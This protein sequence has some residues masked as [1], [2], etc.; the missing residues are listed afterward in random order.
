MIKVIHGEIW[1]EDFTQ[2]NQLIKEF[3]SCVRFAYNRFH[4]DNLEFNDVRKACKAKYPTLNTRQVSDAVV[5]GQALQTRH[6]DE[7]IIF[8]GRKAWEYLKAGNITKEEWL[9]KRDNQ[10]YFRG[11]KTQKGNLNIRIVGVVG[12]YLRITVGTRQWQLY[13]LFVSHK[14]RPILQELLKSGQAYNVRLKRKDDNRFKV[15]IDFQVETP[16]PTIKLDGGVIGVDTNPDRIAL[17]NVTADGNLVETK[18]LI[19]NRILY[20]S[21]DKRYY[22]IGC[23]VKQ[24]IC[25]AKEQ[26]KGIVFENLKFEKDFKPYEKNWNRKKSNFIWNK[27]ITLLERKCIEHGIEYKKVNPAF[28]SIV[29]KYKYRWMHK[30]SI[31]ES[32]AYVIGRRGLG[33]N[34]KLSFYKQEAGAVKAILLRT[35]A[36]K[37]QNVKHHSWRLWKALNDN[38][39]TVLTGL[40]VSL[41]DLKE[42]AGNIRYKSGN[43]LGEIFLLE[44]LAGSKT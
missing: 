18:S 4:K 35:L 38:V 9:S 6:K 15:I 33:Y 37:Y 3:Q 39:E 14:Y 30:L 29:G 27:F 26:N 23:L 16:G 5:Q 19:N 32:A 2:L 41:A 7:K 24:V 10:V 13:K 12:D 8:G 40:R 28:T 36:G 11:D 43:L 22:D 31:H 44:L 25:Y 1:G 21:R 17:A 34:E 42:F 20:A